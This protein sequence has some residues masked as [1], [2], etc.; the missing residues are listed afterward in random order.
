MVCLEAM[1]SRVRQRD[2]VFRS[3]V[4]ILYCVCHMKRHTKDSILLKVIYSEN[5]RLHV[6]TQPNR[7]KS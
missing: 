6:C 4:A 5:D 1:L 3:D 2:G 7:D